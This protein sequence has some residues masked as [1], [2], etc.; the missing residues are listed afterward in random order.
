M[1]YKN[2]TLDEVRVCRG[3]HPS[4]LHVV[5]VVWGHRIMANLCGS[6]GK[7]TTDY[8]CC[9]LDYNIIRGGLPV[10]LVTICLFC[11]FLDIEPFEFEWFW[12]STHRV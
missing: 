10:E 12:S 9:P 4:V 5:H 1:I 7:A 3:A 2:T 8:R 11:G 6:E